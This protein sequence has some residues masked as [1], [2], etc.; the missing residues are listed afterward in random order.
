MEL[1]P[2]D[3]ALARGDFFSLHMPLTPNTKH[4]FNDDAFAKVGGAWAG[5]P[6]RRRSDRALPAA[7]RTGACPA[8]Q[9]Q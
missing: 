9:P 4:L 8:R 7:A 2:F 5:R 6:S 1:V 3:E